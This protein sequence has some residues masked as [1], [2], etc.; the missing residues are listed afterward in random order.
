MRIDG[1]QDGTFR[2][3][4]LARGG[5][6]GQTYVRYGRGSQ[7]TG[8]T[9]W[10]HGLAQSRHTRQ[11]TTDEEREEGLIAYEGERGILNFSKLNQEKS[12]SPEAKEARRIR[13]ADRDRTSPTT[14]WERHIKPE[15]ESQAREK[16]PEIPRTWDE[17]RRGQTAEL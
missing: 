6:H 8:A 11:V 4:I 13:R 16:P 17:L 9:G 5:V 12:L 2:A 7:H 3:V 10:R 14:S 1:R 15:R